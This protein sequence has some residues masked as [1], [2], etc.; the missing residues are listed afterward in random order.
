MN[1]RNQIQPFH[2]TSLMIRQ[3]IQRF[4]SVHPSIYAI[5]DLIEAIPDPLVQQQVREH[6]VCIEDS[7]V[8]S[9]EWTLSRSV[10]DIKLGIVGSIHSGKSALVHRYLTGSY[11]QEESPEGGRFKKEVVIDGQS[12]LLLIRDEGGPPEAQFTHWVDA[13]IFVFSLENESSFSAIYNYYAKMAHFRNTAEIPLILVGTQDAISESNPRVIDDTRARKLANDL[14]RCSY[15]ETCATYGLNVE[16]V[17]Q[18]ACQK[19]VTARMATPAI[20]PQTPNHGSGGGGVPRPF[21]TPGQSQPANPTVPPRTYESHSSSSTTSGSGNIPTSTPPNSSHNIAQNTP[22]VY[23]ESSFTKDDKKEKK[24]KEKLHAQQT[25]QMQRQSPHMQLNIHEPPPPPRGDQLQDIR[26]DSSP[27]KLFRTPSATP[28]ATRKNKKAFNI[29]KS[30]SFNAGTPS[31]DSWWYNNY[32]CSVDI[33]TSQGGPINPDNQRENRTP[34]ST[35]ILSRKNKNK[36]NFLIEKVDNFFKDLQIPPNSPLTP[37][38]G[39]MTRVRSSL[40]LDKPDGKDLPTPT[41]TPTQT[42]KSRR[43]SNLFTPSKKDEERLGSGR[44]IPIR[45]GYLYKKSSKGLNREWKKKYVTLN[46]NGMLTYHPSLHDYMDEVHGKEINLMKTTVKIPGQKPRGSRGPTQPG[47]N[48]VTTE[49]NNLSLGGGK[50][51]NK[52]KENVMQAGGSDQKEGGGPRLGSVS[53]N[54]DD[55]IVISNSSITPGVSNGVDTAIAQMGLSAA[56]MARAETPN[57]KK[58]HRRAKSSSKNVEASQAGDDSDG[59]EFVIVSLDNKQWQ[60][61]APTTDEREGWVSAIEQQILTSLQGNESNKARNRSSTT[62]PEAVKMIRAV[63]GNQ[64]CADCMSP[65]P[66]WASLN[67]G[68]LMCIECSGIH[69]NLGAHVSRVRSLDLD[70]WPPELVGVM[71]LIGNSVSNGVWEAAYITKGKA[72]PTPSTPREDKEKW[73]RAKYDLKEFL[74]PPPHKDHPLG[75]Q[76]IDS[77]TRDDI[78]STVLVLALS[79]PDDVNSSYSAQDG[80]KAIHVAAALGKTPII[81]LILWYGADV[82]AVDHDGRTALWYARTKGAQDCVDLLTHNGCPEN[83]T[84]PRRRGSTQQKS[85]RQ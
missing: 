73:I 51:G 81:Q 82:K 27:H 11:M 19:I 7:F 83:P 42:R 84:L 37:L 21:F 22:S 52:G 41:S 5:Y 35:P 24:S 9:Q 53:S 10:P 25:P 4:E 78:R 1:Q 65:N 31:G 39:R 59:Y 75:R 17:F 29:Q 66:D 62:D 60:F 38:L 12:F 63:R 74:P 77:I 13:V 68:A 72:K 40:D 18:D 43:R 54:C 6:V 50:P 15:Y 45:Q 23:R 67:L 64:F 70:E 20:R 58:R 16:R 85:F 36:S 3:E 71:T 34:T 48:G 56:Q 55:A 14:K 57:V 76:L 28:Q 80:R 26:L 46:D 47:S 44:V 33:S 61:E 8:N 79:T 2:S 32:L 30:N 49:M 69:R